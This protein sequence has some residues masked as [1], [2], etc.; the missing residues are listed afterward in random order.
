MSANYI[1]IKRWFA[2]NRS[3][4]P[5]AHIDRIMEND[6]HALLMTASFEAGREFQMRNPDA[7]K[8]LDDKVYK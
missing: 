1:A 3:D 5:A 7:G 2:E 6:A 8:F 4:I